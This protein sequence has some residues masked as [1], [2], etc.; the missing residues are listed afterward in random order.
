MRKLRLTLITATALI[1]GGSSM[2]L[3]A[4]VGNPG[5][6]R[7]ATE[8]LNLIEHAQYVWGGRQYCWY[9]DGWNGPGWYWCGYALR[10]G[11]GWG[12]PAGYRGWVHRDRMERHER[13]EERR[14]HPEDR[15][16]YRR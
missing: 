7:V 3:A 1:A 11:H 10:R 2:V 16:D 6:I 8:E 12:G 13:R 14:E 4:P 5:E 15:G 9:V